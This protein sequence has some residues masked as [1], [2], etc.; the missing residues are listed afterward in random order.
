MRLGTIM[1]IRYIISNPYGSTLSPQ[2]GI[3]TPPHIFVLAKPTGPKHNPVV[4]Y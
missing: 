2:H 3:G 4:F 1:Y